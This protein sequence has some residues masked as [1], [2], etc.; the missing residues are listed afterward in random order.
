[1]LAADVDFLTV[2]NLRCEPGRPCWF[3]CPVLLCSDVC[4]YFFSDYVCDQ[5]VSVIYRM[6]TPI[7]GVPFQC[8]NGFI[9]SNYKACAE[10][11]LPVVCGI[12]F[13]FVC[14]SSCLFMCLLLSDGTRSS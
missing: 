1:M 7:M 8:D 10:T 13:L 14:T 5:L 11:F 3:S 4:S 6:T 12:I 2:L 9:S